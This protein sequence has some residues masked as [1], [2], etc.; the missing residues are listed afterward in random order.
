MLCL[1]GFDDLRAST[2]HELGQ[3]AG[4]SADEVNRRMGSCHSDL[5]DNWNRM[6]KDPTNNDQLLAFYNADLTEAYELAAWHAGDGGSYPLKYL[7]ALDFAAK[8]GAKRILD[9]GSGVG[10]GTILFTKAGCQV[11]YAD[12][13]TPLLDLVAYRL[14][15]R[16]LDAKQ[17]NL[18]TQTPE[19]GKYD[20]ICSYDVL[21]HVPDPAAELAKLRS[22]LRPGGWIIANLFPEGTEAEAVPLH[23][24]TI[25][26]VHVFITTTGLWA[27]WY[28]TT[29]LLPYRCDGIALHKTWWAPLLNQVRRLRYRFSKPAQPKPAARA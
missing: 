7:A 24:S 27:D 5:A 2:V 10:S 14:K 9:F 18:K 4:V 22:Y 11:D 25:P 20:L 6:V 15:V 1:P 29:E 28:A 17:I 8:R 21:E 3:Y 23:I 26:D 19:V 12:I 13:A 16:G